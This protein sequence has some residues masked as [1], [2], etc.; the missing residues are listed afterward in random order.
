MTTENKQSVMHERWRK[1]R[2]T[3]AREES[4]S[5]SSHNI[6]LPELNPWPLVSADAIV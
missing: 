4:H 3:A 2:D 6:T 5:P 1:V